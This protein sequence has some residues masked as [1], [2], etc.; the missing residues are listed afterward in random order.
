MNIESYRLYC[1][2]EDSARHDVY[3]H[4][5]KYVA[6]HA[7]DVVIMADLQTDEYVFIATC[8]WCGKDIINRRK[9]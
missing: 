7:K 9:M 3:W 4:D 6:I 2:G 1:D 5:G 8:P